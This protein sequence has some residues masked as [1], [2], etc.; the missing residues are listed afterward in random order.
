MEVEQS[1][2]SLKIDSQNAM[3]KDS[4]DWLSNLHVTETNDV[5]NSLA[6]STKDWISEIKT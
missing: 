1:L 4:F 3:Q 6:L 2:K 5:L